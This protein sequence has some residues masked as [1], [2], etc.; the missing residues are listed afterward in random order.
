MM[1]M[2]IIFIKS[3]LLKWVN[4]SGAKGSFFNLKQRSQVDNGPIY[5]SS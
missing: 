2:M 1:M 5:I 4:I 3:V